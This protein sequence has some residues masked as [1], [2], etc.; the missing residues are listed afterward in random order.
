MVNHGFI[1]GEI[2]RYLKN[3]T[4]G[5]MLVQMSSAYTQIEDNS[6]ISGL[7]EITLSGF[8]SIFLR[9]NMLAIIMEGHYNGKKHKILIFSRKY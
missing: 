1:N 8:V 5:E 6:N 3:A 2:V 4:L 7:C 9:F